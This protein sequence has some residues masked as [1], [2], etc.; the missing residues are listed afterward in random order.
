MNVHQVLGREYDK[1]ACIL[2][3]WVDY[4]KETGICGNCH[5]WYP[6]LIKNSVLETLSRVRKKLTIIVIDN[7]N[8]Y[9]K[10]AELL[11]KK[12][13]KEYQN[14]HDGIG[15][16]LNK[17]TEELNKDKNK[18]NELNDFAVDISNWAQQNRLDLEA[19]AQ[20]L[21]KKLLDKYY[22]TRVES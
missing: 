14:K 5:D 4:D 6:Y 18:M 8:L 17:L 19:V 1:V 16:K 11:T 9:V 21:R 15:T 12:K 3:D 2:D 13:V 22:E 7:P 20:K 10:I